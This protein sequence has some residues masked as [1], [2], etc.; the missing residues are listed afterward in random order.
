MKTS[1]FLLLS[2]FLF[3]P[4]FSQKQTKL[5]ITALERTDGRAYKND[6]LYLEFQAKKH[7]ISYKFNRKTQ[8]LETDKYLVE[9]FRGLNKRRRF[10]DKEKITK[11]QNWEN[12]I[13]L[14]DFENLLFHLKTDVD[15]LEKKLEISHTS[16]HYFHLYITII[17]GRLKMNYIKTKP[18]EYLTP[19]WTTEELGDSILNPAIDEF[20]YS[21]LPEGFMNREKLKPEPVEFKDD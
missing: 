17:Q 7:E 13:N 1:L 12:H 15:S 5:I 9:T 2:L 3:Q 4:T 16:H 20:I 6:K 11:Y 10:I 14:E 18:F 8:K 21:I 19:W